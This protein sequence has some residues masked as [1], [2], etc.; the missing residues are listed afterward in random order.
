MSARV[1]GGSSTRPPKEPFTFRVGGE[2][3]PEFTVHQPDAGTVM[4][5]EEATTSR[6]VL[7]L[8]MGEQFGALMEA[9]EAQHPDVLVD[10]SR[11][12]SR[13]FG[14]FD[15]AANRAERRRRE[16]SH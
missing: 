16:R 11:D 4:D 7:K 14:L 15:G 1:Y 3:C 5:I 8:F 2:D 10:I 13:H 9:I 6:Q 12:I